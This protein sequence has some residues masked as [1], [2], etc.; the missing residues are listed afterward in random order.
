MATTHEFT[1]SWGDDY[2]Q[3]TIDTGPGGRQAYLDLGEHRMVVRQLTGMKS[4][5][6][7]APSIIQTHSIEGAPFEVQCVVEL[8]DAAITL[9]NT[10][11]EDIGTKWK[12]PKKK[13]K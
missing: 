4:D 1:R 12:E 11:A 8:F 13:K 10:W 6:L 5:L 9:A 2:I 7:D 3:T